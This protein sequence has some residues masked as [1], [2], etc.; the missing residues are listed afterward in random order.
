MDH[1]QHILRSLS[2]LCLMACLS[3]TP[4]L[5]ERHV[6]GHMRERSPNFIFIL[7][8]DLGWSS[9]SLRMDDRVDGSRSDFHDTPQMERLAARSL[10][11]TRGY[12]PDPICSPTRRSLQF[13]QSSIRQDDEPFI[14]RYAPR[15]DLPWKTIP[16]VL[17]GI[18]P[19]YRAAHFGKWDLRNGKGPE[20]YGYDEGDGDTGNGQGNVVSGKEEKWTQHTTRD[21]AKQTDSLTIRAIDF[22]RRQQREGHP[23]YLQVSHYAT[24]ANIETSAAGLARFEGKPRGKKHDNPAWAGMLFDL[25]RAVG[26][27]MEELDRLGISDHTYVILM[28]DNGGVEFIPPV[29]NRLDHPSTFDRPMRNAPLRGGKWTLYEGGIRVPFMVSGPGIKPGQTNVPAIGWDIL[30]TIT[31]LAGGDPGKLKDLD[32]GSL[33]PVL[34]GRPD[35]RVQRP[36]EALYFHRFHKGYGHSAVIQDDHKLI[37]FWKTGKVELF[38]LSKDPGELKDLSAIDPER[39]RALDRLLSD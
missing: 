36:T 28:A 17:K 6:S 24:H 27:L 9:L 29:S 23:F 26:K 5:D 10:R 19:R 35:A 25:D 34:N 16:Q 8:D 37:R 18:Q 15:P 4:H 22:M 21:N 7:T 32:G 39:T 38:D 30:P 13:G 20:A 12:S 11:F 3:F 1:T 14:A 2:W 31:Q 33:V